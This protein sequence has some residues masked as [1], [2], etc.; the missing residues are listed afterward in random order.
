MAKTLMDFCYGLHT[1]FYSARVIGRVEPRERVHVPVCHLNMIMVDLRTFGVVSLAVLAATAQGAPRRAL[2]S[3]A[4]RSGALRRQAPPPPDSA[5]LS[6]A[7]SYATQYAPP[8]D[9][10]YLSKAN[11]YATAWDGR[12][13]G[14]APPKATTP[15]PPA[16]PSPPPAQRPGDQAKPVASGALSSANSYATQYAPSEAQPYLSQAHSYA[17]AWSG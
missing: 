11:S 6:S 10:G 13:R 14:D 5:A 16:T 2:Y 12:A 9:S 15:P 3:N 4:D 8:A 17:T 7:H 1:P